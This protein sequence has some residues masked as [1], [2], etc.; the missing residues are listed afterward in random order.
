MGECYRKTI[1]VLLFRVA[2]FLCFLGTQ[3]KLLPIS[4]YKLVS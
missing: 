2:H 4:M 3:V 1:I